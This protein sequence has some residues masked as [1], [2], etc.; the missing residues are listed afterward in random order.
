[1]ECKHL[2]LFEVAV[3]KRLRQKTASILVTGKG[4]G[5]AGEYGAKWR[6]DTLEDRIYILASSRIVDVGELTQAGNKPEQFHVDD[7]NT[8][9]E[10]V[11][12]EDK[13]PSVYNR[14][15]QL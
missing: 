2:L 14:K 13:K 12:G 6:R 5:V 1:M 9:H 8:K 4:V 11:M 3:R 15:R 7:G 10:S